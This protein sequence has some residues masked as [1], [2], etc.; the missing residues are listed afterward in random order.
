MIFIDDIAI[1]VPILGADSSRAARGEGERRFFKEG[2]LLGI[3]IILEISQCFSSSST[4]SFIKSAPFRQRLGNEDA[5]LAND[6]L[7]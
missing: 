1:E 7:H 6:H 2:T 4:F 5:V 3:P